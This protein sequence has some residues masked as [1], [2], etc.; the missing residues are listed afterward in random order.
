MKLT[1]LP[2]QSLVPGRWYVG[3]GRN[4]NVAL[5]DG[6]IFLIIGDEG[7]EAVI[8]GEPYYE[9]E[10][11]CFQP[12]LIAEQRHLTE[13][14]VLPKSQLTSRRWYLGRGATSNLALWDAGYF[15]TI[16]EASGQRLVR[17]EPCYE[18]MSGCF[19]PFLLIAEGR[20]V[21]PFGKHGWEAHYGSVLEI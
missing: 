11:G 7:G 3:R 18:E 19:Q 14:A 10:C 12:F 4:A 8:K 15:V 17:R 5:W 13:P 9:V 6:E 20:M 1:V 16:D 2:K 21:E